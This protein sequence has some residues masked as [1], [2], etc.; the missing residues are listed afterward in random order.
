M[1]G[2]LYKEGSFIDQLALSLAQV[3]CRSHPNGKHLDGYVIFV[4]YCNIQVEMRPPTINDGV[5]LHC[6]YMPTFLR[7]Y[8]TTTVT[9]SIF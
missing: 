5:E 1:E 8:L 4:R 2:S 9:S 6:D 7:C 3:S